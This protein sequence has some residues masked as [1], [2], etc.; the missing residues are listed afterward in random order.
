MSIDPTDK[1]LVES[2]LERGKRRGD[3]DVVEPKSTTDDEVLAGGARPAVVAELGLDVA[4]DEAAQAPWEEPPAKLDAA[5]QEEPT[6]EELEAIAADMIGIDDPVR[7]Y[8]KEIG[9]VPLL[10]AEEEVVL[11][12]AIELGEQMVD[13]PQKA[14]LSLWEWTKNDTEAKS[15]TKHPQHRLPYKEETDG[16]VRAAFRAAEK[17]GLLQP[18][19]DLH[20]VKWQRSAEGENTK[21]WL[22][23]AKLLVHAYNEAPDAEK[24]TELV[25]FAFRAVHDGDVEAHDNQG[26]R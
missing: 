18:I 3:D 14:I 21:H 15:R 13:E 8:L 25:D 10:N 17:D 9:K 23:E 24:F 5:E 16:I 22:K 2:V 7:M 11:A 1:L 4:V 6:P 19:P 26:L 20:L 12:K